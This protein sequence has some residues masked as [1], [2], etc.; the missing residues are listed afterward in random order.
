PCPLVQPL[1]RP[2]P[3]PTSSPATSISPT[4]PAGGPTTAPG[5]PATL[6]RPPPSSMSSSGPLTS[7]STKA[8]RQALLPLGS[9]VTR[10]PTIP[11]IPAMRPSVAISQTAD[12]PISTPPTSPCRLA[13]QSTLPPSLR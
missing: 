13:L 10:L 9:V 2:V 8:T 5:A 3:T 4:P 1:P 12:S 6:P 11:L 7:P